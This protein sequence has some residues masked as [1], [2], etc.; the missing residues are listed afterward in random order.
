MKMLQL[1]IKNWT[2]LYPVLK[3]KF[4]VTI[5][6]ALLTGLIFYTGTTTFRLLTQCHGA[7]RLCSVCSASG[8]SPFT[9]YY[10]F[11]LYTL[12]IY[13]INK[14]LEMPWTGGYLPNSISFMLKFDYGRLEMTIYE[15]LSLAINI[16]ILILTALSYLKDKNE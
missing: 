4:D 2:I 3:N 10:L 9:S 11:F 7:Q 5:P 16:A 1:L 14:I 15:I 12:Q 8:G 6:F 13:G